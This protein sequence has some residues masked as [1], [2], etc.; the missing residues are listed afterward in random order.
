[1]R[2]HRSIERDFPHIVETAVRHGWG[3]TRDAMK[4]FHARHGLQPHAKRRRYKDGSCYM[5][6]CFADRDMAEAFAAK[7]AKDI[8][9]LNT[10][11]L[12]I[13][14]ARWRDHLL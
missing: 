5:R 2:R 13:Y 14:A 7:F 9:P 10:P 11:T 6:W 4:D 3:G 12:V 8:V 1:M